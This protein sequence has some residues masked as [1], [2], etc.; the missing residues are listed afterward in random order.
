MKITL[1]PA[2]NL[3]L[4]LSVLAVLLL[5][6]V[7]ASRFSIPT[8]LAGSLFPLFLTGTYR[9]SEIAGEKFSTQF[10]LAFIPLKKERCRLPAVMFIHTTFQANQT[11]CLTFVLF[12]PMQWLFGMVF[13]RLIPSV[14]GP[15]EIWLETAKGRE[16]MAWKGY[17]QSQFES[18]RDLLRNHTQAEVRLR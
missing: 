17:D 6:L 9:V 15:Y 4:R 16:L 5:I 3:T 11:G 18:N 8:I 10:H 14:G 2:A 13:D 12:G 7:V 1:K